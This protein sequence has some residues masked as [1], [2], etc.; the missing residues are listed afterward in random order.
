[1]KAGDLIKKLAQFSPDTEVWVIYDGSYA[2]EADFD[3]IS[4]KESI[5]W[6]EDGIKPGDLVMQVG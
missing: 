4:E 1:M 3:P 2:F 6:Q 5:D